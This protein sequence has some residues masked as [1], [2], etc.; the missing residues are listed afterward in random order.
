ME[1]QRTGGMTA[2]AVL[3]I[4]FGGVEILNGLYLVLGASAL[5]YELSR[6]DVFQIP[7]ARLAY[8]LLI[9]ATGIVGLIAGIGIFAPRPWG[10]AL[11]LVYGLLLMFSAA[12]SFFAVPV[13]A[14]IGTYDIGSLSADGLARLIIFGVIYVVFP[15]PYALLLYFVFYKPPRRPTFG[16]DRLPAILGGT[17]E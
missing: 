12:L 9:L 3:N 13:I 10:R 16:K 7:V 1:R 5:M 11:S 15:A 17:Q 6:L 2:I 4:I 14:S 8:A